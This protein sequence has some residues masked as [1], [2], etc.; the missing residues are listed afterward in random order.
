MDNKVKSTSA[1]GTFNTPTLKLQQLGEIFN[2]A[3]AKDYYSEFRIFCS[4][5]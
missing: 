4:I 2:K 5:S 1:S 3:F